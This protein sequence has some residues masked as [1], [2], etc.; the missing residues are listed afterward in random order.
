MAESAA[1]RRLKQVA[2]DWLRSRGFVAVGDE[3]HLAAG[4]FR[5]DVAAWTDRQVDG[6]SA[7]RC[8]ARTTIV[9]CKVSRGDLARDSQ[10]AVHLLGRRAT[11]TSELRGYHAGP[12]RSLRRMCGDEPTLFDTRGTSVGSVSQRIRRLRLELVA[13]D[14]RLQGRSKFAKMAWWRAADTLWIAAPAGMVH[15]GDVPAGWGLLEWDGA[16]HLVPSIRPPRLDSTDR[17]RQRLLRGIAVSGSRARWP[18]SQ[19]P[20]GLWR[21]AC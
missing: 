20:G 6:V 5:A 12:G 18:G 19:R 4:G 13:I 17:D 16:G 11:V 2:G 21:G 3:V 10:R 7:A 8:P 15:R 1:H 14:R 9:E